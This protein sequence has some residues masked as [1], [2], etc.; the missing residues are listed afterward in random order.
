MAGYASLTRPTNMEKL[1][2]AKGI[3]P[4]FAAWEATVLPLRALFLDLP[5]SRRDEGASR[6]RR[7]ARPQA[8]AGKFYFA[9]AL[10]EDDGR[11]LRSSHF[12]S[13]STCCVQRGP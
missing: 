13:P 3:E 8:E 2:R 1:E 4:T 5:W 10:R 9:L 12:N 7:S 6:I 11:C